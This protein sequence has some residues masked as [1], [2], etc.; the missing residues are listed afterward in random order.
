VPL[1][2]N[3]QNKSNRI[4]MQ[5][6][7]AA[8]SLP[9]LVS[10]GRGYGSCK[11]AFCALCSYLLIRKEKKDE[12]MKRGTGMGVS[13]RMIDFSIFFILN[14]QKKIA[15]QFP[16]SYRAG[17]ASV[18]VES[19]AKQKKIIIRFKTRS[20]ADSRRRRCAN[21]WPTRKSLEHSRAC[22]IVR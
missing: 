18:G 10:E 7:R 8:H 9:A 2:S 3:W 13:E 15:P 22:R 11:S 12:N 4:L 21:V 5:L 19:L 14:R 1:I 17:T 6:G 16:R 20:T